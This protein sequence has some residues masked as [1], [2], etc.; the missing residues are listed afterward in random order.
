MTRTGCGYICKHI[1]YASES[2]LQHVSRMLKM[3]NYICEN[4]L[5]YNTNTALASRSIMCVCN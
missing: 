4:V 1:L 5:L 2:Y 3:F